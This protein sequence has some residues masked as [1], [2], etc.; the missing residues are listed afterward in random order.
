MAQPSGSFPDLVLLS[1]YGILIKLERLIKF[2]AVG[3]QFNFIFISRSRLG[4]RAETPWPPTLL[5]TAWYYFH[6]EGVKDSQT[7]THLIGIP[8]VT[9][10]SLE[11]ASVEGSGYQE[12]DT[13]GVCI[14]SSQYHSGNGLKEWP[15]HTREPWTRSLRSHTSP[16]DFSWCGSPLPALCCSRA[17]LSL[18]SAQEGKNER[19][20]HQLASKRLAI[21]VI[22]CHVGHGPQG[23]CLGSPTLPDVEYIRVGSFFI[24]SPPGLQ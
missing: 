23:M 21:N 20:T 22:L 9:V 7:S 10:I 6:L 5:S 11:I 18:R 2:L 12:V 19:I 15:A 14:A 1:F 4:A 13:V 3:D 17:W 24:S 16:T 8:I